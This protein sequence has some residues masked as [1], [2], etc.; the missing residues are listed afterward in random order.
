MKFPVVTVFFGEVAGVSADEEAIRDGA[1]DWSRVAPLL[2]TFPQKGY[3]T[4]GDHV[5]QAWSVG[6]SCN[7]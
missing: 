3:W 6:K 7:P 4:P 1:S 2:V 5:A